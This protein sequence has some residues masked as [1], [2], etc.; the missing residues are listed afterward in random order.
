MTA[1]FLQWFLAQKPFRQCRLVMKDGTEEL[2]IS[3]E[4]VRFDEYDMIRIVKNKTLGVFGIES[5][6]LREVQEIRQ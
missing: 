6:N 2:I 1:E 3:P 4:H 5:I